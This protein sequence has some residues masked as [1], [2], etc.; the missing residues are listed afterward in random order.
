MR[1]WPFWPNKRALLEDRWLST[2]HPPATRWL[3]LIVAPAASLCVRSCRACVPSVSFCIQ[4][5]PFLYEWLNSLRSPPPSFED[6][7]KIAEGDTVKKWW[8]ST[9]ASGVLN[10]YVAPEVRQCA[11]YFAT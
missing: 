1:S 7:R 4:G 8:T 5:L 6:C 10:D 9:L 3:R 11:T 2:L